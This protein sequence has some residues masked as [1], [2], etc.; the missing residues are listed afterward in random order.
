MRWRWSHRGFG[1]AITLSKPAAHADGVP[2][3]SH[4]VGYA[5]GDSQSY[6]EGTEYRTLIEPTNRG[7]DT[8][9]RTDIYS[10]AD[11]QPRTDT[12][13]RTDSRSRADS[14]SSTDIYSRADAQPRT[15][16]RS[17]TDSDAI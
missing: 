12:R 2:A 5:P 6:A 14:R 3:H 13:S 17:R 15:D 11:A 8:C 7:A 4:E 9:S 16:T 1:I 10:R